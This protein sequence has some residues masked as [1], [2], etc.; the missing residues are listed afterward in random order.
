MVIELKEL[1]NMRLYTHTW[2]YTHTEVRTHVWAWTLNK[3]LHR[4]WCRVDFPVSLKHVDKQM[5]KETSTY[6]IEP[7]SL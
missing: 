4:L 6:V 2:I 1:R 3:K 7:F 5:K